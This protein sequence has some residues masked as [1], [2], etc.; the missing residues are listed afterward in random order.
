MVN[1]RFGLLT[2][3]ILLCCE[4][5]PSGLGRDTLPAK[6][7][8]VTPSPS[9]QSQR[10]LEQFYDNQVLQQ[11]DEAW[12]QVAKSAGRTL[13]ESAG[14][15]ATTYSDNSARL[16]PIPGTDDPGV[17]M[18][19]V[20]RPHDVYDRPDNSFLLRAITL[21]LKEVSAENGYYVV[22]V[23]VLVHRTEPATFDESSSSLARPTGPVLLLEST[24]LASTVE[25]IHFDRGDLSEVIELSER[26]DDPQGFLSRAK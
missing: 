16:I 23:R 24:Y 4:C 5:A 7:A 25:K 1:K 20:L 6:A 12:D 26:L 17:R 18:N 2:I 10:L 11:P 21:A 13:A 19:L 15:N 22:M 3:S 9:D 14:L 8:S